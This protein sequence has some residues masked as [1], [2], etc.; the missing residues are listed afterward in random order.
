VEIQVEV[1]VQVAVV[2]YLHRGGGNTILQWQEKIQPFGYHNFMEK[3]RRTQRNIYLFVKIFG[4]LNR[5]QMKT[6]KWLNLQ[7]HSETMHWTG[8]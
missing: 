8:L 7:S 5:S 2:S 6:Q 4:K 3:G 1:Q